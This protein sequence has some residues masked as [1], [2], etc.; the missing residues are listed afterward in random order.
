[1]YADPHFNLG[2]TLTRQMKIDEAIGEFRQA[3]ELSPR[4]YDAHAQLGIA[5]AMQDRIDEAIASFE[6]ALRLRPD[7]EDAKKYL[8]LAR[9]QKAQRAGG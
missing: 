4:S 9:Q 2:L 1:M 8:Q 7:S 5:L 6:E 3:V